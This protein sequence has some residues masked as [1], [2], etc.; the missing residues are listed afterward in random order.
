VSKSSFID[1]QF[2]EIVTPQ[3]PTDNT[4]LIITVTCLVA[5]AIIITLYLLVN[6]N[7]KITAAQKLKAIKKQNKFVASNY[8]YLALEVAATLRM[9]FRVSNLDRLLPTSGTHEEWQRFR[10]RLSES[11]YGRNPPSPDEIDYLASAARSWL[12]SLSVSKIKAD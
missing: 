10:L 11:C 3:A 1:N 5:L 9:A 8:R 6:R 12:R 4:V 2:V 7:T